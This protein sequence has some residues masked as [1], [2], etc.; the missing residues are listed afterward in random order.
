MMSG[1]TMGMMGQMGAH[2]QQMVELMNR[3]M[4]SM[5][6]IEAEK[7]PAALKTKLAAHK[8]LLEQMHSQMMVQ[9]GMMQRM[10]HMHQMMGASGNS[11]APASK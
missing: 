3:L 5:S 1:G 4:Q 9:G 8:A 2:H 6:A 7:D 11:Q 10:Q